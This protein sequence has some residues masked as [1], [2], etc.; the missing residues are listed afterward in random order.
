MTR[1]MCDA[2]KVRAHTTQKTG[3]HATKHSKFVENILFT[4]RIVENVEIW[5]EM[6]WFWSGNVYHVERNRRCFMS[7]KKNELEHT[8]SHSN[9]G[10]LAVTEH[11][12]YFVIRFDVELTFLLVH[13]YTLIWFNCSEQVQ[14][15]YFLFNGEREKKLPQ[16]N[17]SEKDTAQHYAMPLYVV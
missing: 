7:K 9:N 3:Q 8:R 15:V 12:L 6:W 16:K 11:L 2:I 1:R 5:I 14:I 13:K 10:L 17:Y 4:R